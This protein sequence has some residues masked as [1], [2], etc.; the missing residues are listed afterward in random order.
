MTSSPWTEAASLLALATYLACSLGTGVARGKYK[1]KAPAV[2]G[3]EMF[4]RAYRVQMNTLEQIVFFL[5]SMWLFAMLVSDKIAAIG[6][7]V[8][9]IG[10]IVYAVSYLRNPASRGAGFAISFFTSFALFLGA[11]YGLVKTL[12]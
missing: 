2:T 6:G 11:A 4:E 7:V 8:W 12:M 9:V 5:P 1:V 3:H 10:R